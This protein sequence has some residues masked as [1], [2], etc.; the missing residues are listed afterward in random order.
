MEQLLNILISYLTVLYSQFMFDVD[1]FSQ[2]WMYAF[3]CIPAG[4]YLVFFIL[5]WVVLTLPITF[6][7]GG[8]IG[9]IVRSPFTLIAKA[10]KKSR[11]NRG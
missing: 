9:A 4:G 5:K 3:L 8:T 7:V 11:R 1:V 2:W 6:L 10:V